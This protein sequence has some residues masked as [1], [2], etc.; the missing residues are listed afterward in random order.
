MAFSKGTVS[1][2][3]GDIR[4][5]IGVASV[6]V[7]SVNPTKSMLEELYGRSLDKAPEYVGDTEIGP[8]GDKKKV[9]QVR[10]DFVVKADP[11]KY[12]DSQ[13]QPLEFISKVSLYLANSFRYNKDQSKVQVIDKYGRTAWVSVE[14]AKNHV[15]PMYTNGPANIDKGYRPAYIGEEDLI[16][17]LKAYLNIPRVEKWENSQVVGLIDHPEDAEAG[18]DHIPD[19]FKG[20]FSELQD[21]IG[22]Q[23]NNKVK[24]LFGIK[25]TDE[26]KLYQT[27][28]TRM[29]LKNNITDY[30]KLDKS[31]KETQEAGAL[32]SSEFDCTE[33]HEY[34]VDNTNFTQGVGAEMPFPP[35]PASTPWGNRA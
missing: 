18:L 20:D 1:T 24:V 30:S 32:S 7:L 22:Y 6:Y 14:D 29:F 13:G 27:V 3:G 16:N 35:A 34:V 11:E 28:Y 4:R 10:I 12:C 8:E 5:Y 17:F 19:Y 23:P 31:V 26:N 9:A 2:E 15:I 25:T 33:L 21:I